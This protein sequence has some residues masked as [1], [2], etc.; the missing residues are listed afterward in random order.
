MELNMTEAH[1]KPPFAVTSDPG[2]D[3]KNPFPSRLSEHRSLTLPGS[4]KDTRHFVFNISGSGLTYTPGDSLGVFARNPAALVQEVLQ[5]LHLAPETPVLQAAGPVEPL[6][7]VLEH[8]YIL[9][10]VNRKFVNALA[11]L[12]PAGPDQARLQGLLA[13]PEALNQYVFSRDY[14]DVL[15]EFPSVRPPSADWLLNTLT[16]IPP[17]LYSIASSLQA[18]PGE[19]HLCVAIVRYHTHGRDK[20]GLCTGYLADHTRIH[21][22]RIP[23]YVQTSKSFR[24]P[25]DSSRDIIMVGPGTGIAP[26]RAFLEERGL[27]G[28]AGRHWLVF[29]EQHRASDFLYGKELTDWHKSGLLHR[30]DLAFSRDQDHKIYVQNRLKEQAAAVWDWLQNGAYFYVCGDA[31]H[32]AKDVHQALKEIAMEQ[33]GLSREQA[34]EY[35]DHTLMKTE[36]RYL[37]DIY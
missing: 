24:L 37:R 7:S 6:A 32:M 16:P 15:A 34:D 3:R 4:L 18:H 20:T 2:Y 22:T 30:L 17:R 27:A 13:D 29:G 25:E 5:G 31:K 11:T 36:K 12:L 1:G 33:G 28:A 8:R 9:N 35:V 19:V 23:V 21:E 14:V 10:R 26:F